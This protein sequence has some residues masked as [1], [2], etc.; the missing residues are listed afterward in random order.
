MVRS[1][2]WWYFWSYLWWL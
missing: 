2:N 1:Y